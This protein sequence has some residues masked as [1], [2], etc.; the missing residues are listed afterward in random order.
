MPFSTHKT[1]TIANTLTLPNFKHNYPLKF[2]V[3]ITEKEFLNTH[4]HLERW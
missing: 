3:L 2:K 1:Y 4:V